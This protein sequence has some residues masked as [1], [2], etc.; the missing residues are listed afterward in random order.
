MIIDNPKQVE[1]YLAEERYSTEEIVEKVNAAYER[2]ANG[3]KPAHLVWVD[4]DS[5]W[6]DDWALYLVFWEGEPLI[7][8]D[9]SMVG[10]I[11]SSQLVYSHR[12]IRQGS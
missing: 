2:L 12:E 1:S 11:L 9:G 4:T 7:K 8:E 6:F 5:G 10:I 3:R